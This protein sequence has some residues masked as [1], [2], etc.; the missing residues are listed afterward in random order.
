MFRLAV[1][2]CVFVAALAQFGAY[3]DGEWAAYKVAYNKVY[4]SPIEPIR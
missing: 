3:L 2:A 1:L 4:D